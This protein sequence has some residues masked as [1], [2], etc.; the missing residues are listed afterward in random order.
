MATRGLIDRKGELFAYLRG[1]T[2][3][4]LDDELTGTL[5]DG[6]IVDTAGNRVWRVEGDALRTLDGS[7]TIGFLGSELADDLDY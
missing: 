1:D 7:E 6:F 4:T 5:Q 3:Y 2:L